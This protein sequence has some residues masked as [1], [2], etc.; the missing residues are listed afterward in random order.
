MLLK[1]RQVA[2][3]LD[4]D[5]EHTAVRLV[6]SFAE[7]TFNAGTEEAPHYAGTSK[8]LTCPSSGRT[9]FHHVFMCGETSYLGPL[10]IAIT[11]RVLDNIFLRLPSS[12]LRSYCLPF[13]TLCVSVVPVS[14]ARGTCDVTCRLSRGRARPIGMSRLRVARVCWLG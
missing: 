7:D 9:P 8:P 4:F 12:P 11:V 10:T 3:N 13:T 5:A 1:W 2:G 6:C 14:L